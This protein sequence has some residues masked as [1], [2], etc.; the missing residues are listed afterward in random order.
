MPH[1][2]MIPTN[3]QALLHAWKVCNHMAMRLA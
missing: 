2:Y 3:Y 1:P